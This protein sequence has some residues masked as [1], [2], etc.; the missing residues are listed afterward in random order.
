MRAV[1]LAAVQPTTR[2]RKRAP[3]SRHSFR[4][5]SLNTPDLK[6][7]AR[8]KSFSERTRTRTELYEGEHP[9]PLARPLVEP[10][11]QRIPIESH[12]R[13]SNLGCTAPS[14]GS[15]PVP[16]ASLLLEP[17]RQGIP[18]ETHL[19]PGGLVCTSQSRGTDPMPLASLLVDKLSQ[20][21]P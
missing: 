11:R 4:V 13:L 5:G 16:R 6:L 21:I 2:P 12:P 9:V 19:R 7:Q 1:T 14:K 18:V 8:L 17:Y 10:N 20:G 3:I 15:H